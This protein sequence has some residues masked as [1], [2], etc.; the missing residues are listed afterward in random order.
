MEFLLELIVHGDLC[1][2]ILVAGLLC[3]VGR[4]V[5]RGDPAVQGWGMQLALI[6]FIAFGL[7]GMGRLSEPDANAVLLVVMRALVA[8]GL[9]LGASWVVLPLVVLTYQHLRRATEAAKAR[10]EKRRSGRER[11]RIERAEQ[12][13]RRQQ[14]REW[15]RRAPQ[16]KQEARK[17]EERRQ[18]EEDEQ[19]QRAEAEA[20]AQKRR[21]DTR[22]ACRLLY[23]RLTPDQRQR[24]PQER[25]DAY[26]KEYLSDGHSADY[27][28][29]C[30]E[31]LQAMIRE[32]FNPQSSA[33]QKY[34]SL[35]E[36]AD[37]FRQRR[38]E[39][40]HLDYDQR[41]KDVFLAILADEE[42]E[43]IRGFFSP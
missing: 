5:V 8:G 4:Y 24:F 2:L 1:S 20:Q 7:F 40:E 29:Q 23:D 16:R 12:Q 37:Q 6:G 33:Q 18:R 28:E 13:R 34:G 43:T 30:G 10:L 3:I 11:Q 41:T 22:L 27:V 19:R 42:Q 9:T 31:Q 25:F 32:C 14:Q 17:A 21:N 38:Q 26:L 15:E 39:I 35:K 36:I